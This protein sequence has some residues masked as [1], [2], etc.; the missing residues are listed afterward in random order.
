M[1]CWTG[2]VC[3]ENLGNQWEWVKSQ[4]SCRKDPMD[5][6][7]GTSKYFKIIISKYFRIAGILPLPL[8]HAS[9]LIMGTSDL[10]PGGCDQDML[11]GHEEL[12]VGTHWSLDDMGKFSKIASN[13]LKPRFLRVVP[14]RAP[15]PCEGLIFQCFRQYSETWTWYLSVFFGKTLEELQLRRCCKS[16]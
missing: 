9:V 15:V 3:H 10:A 4:G 12:D 8:S 11:G 7:E 1:V 5:V 6:Y 2:A 13:R 16:M 14:V